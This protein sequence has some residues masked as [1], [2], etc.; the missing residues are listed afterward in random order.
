MGVCEAFCW[1]SAVSCCD[2]ISL[3]CQKICLVLALVEVPEEI[4]GSVAASC[5]DESVSDVVDIAFVFREGGCA[6]VVA[7]YS[8]G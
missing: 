8:K 1:G 4:S 3:G 5:E 2:A 6:S 7:E